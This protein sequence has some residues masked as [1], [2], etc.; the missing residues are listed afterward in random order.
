MPWEK[1]P[2]DTVG[3]ELGW[4]LLGVE[5]DVD[6]IGLESC[7]LGVDLCPGGA[8]DAVGDVEGPESN[9]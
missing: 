2:S 3:E 4:A 7:A 5:V 6:W 1:W 8:G 9:S